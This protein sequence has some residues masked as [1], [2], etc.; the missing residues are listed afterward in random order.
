[1]ALGTKGEIP[2]VEY[3]LMRQRQ[4]MR[5]LQNELVRTLEEADR[6][7]KYIVSVGK[8]INCIKETGVYQTEDTI[9]Y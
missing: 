2:D 3:D 9:P 6:L 5:D 8:R 4:M 7:E 1:M